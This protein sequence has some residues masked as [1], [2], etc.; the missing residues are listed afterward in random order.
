MLVAH[1]CAAE[2]GGQL[3]SHSSEASARNAVA[4]TDFSVGVVE[5]SDVEQLVHKGWH[6]VVRALVLK[7]HS[8][9][10]AGVRVTAQ[11]REAVRA[12][13]NKLDDLIRVLDRNYGKAS[14]VSPASQWAQN[15]THVFLSV[16]FAQRWNAPGALE[17]ENETVDITGC[18]FNFTAFGEHSFIVRRYHLSWELLR[19][20]LPEASTWYLASAGRMAVTFAKKQAENWPR[21]HRSVG[22][23]PKNLGIWRD[24]REKWNSELQEFVPLE[25]DKQGVVVKAKAKTKPAEKTSKKSKGHKRAKVDEDEE[26]EDDAL[27]RELELVSDCPKASF[28]GTSVAELCAKSWADVVES[29]RVKNR[30]WLVQLYSSQGEGDP[31]S[32]RSLMRVWKRLAD[33]FPSMVSTGRVGALDCGVD[34][35]LCKKLGAPMAKLPQVRRFAAGG[36]GEVWKGSLDASIE[37]FAAFGGDGRAEL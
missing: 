7:S 3:S 6:E 25:V 23:A 15:S 9:E 16:K 26:E 34:R 30:R 35:E 33:V 17:V 10:D 2:A 19:P 24:M 36:E 5:A 27:D 12:E 29:P 37:E 22:A 13:R 14:E 20:V 18:C 8:E 31:E 1:V 28:M 4:A 11:V 21:L 32:T